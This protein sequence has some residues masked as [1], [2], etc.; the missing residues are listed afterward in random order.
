MTTAQPGIFAQGTRAHYYLELDVLPG[1]D[2]DA[3][4]AALAALREPPVTAGGSNFVIALGPWLWRQLAPAEA[5]ASL[6]DF[7]VIGDPAGR[8]APATQHDI[9]LWFH[10]TN[11]DVVL[12]MA[13]AA[14][15]ALSPVAELA[16]HQPAFVY[17]DSRDMTGFIDGTENS[18]LWEAPAVALVPDGEPGAGGSHVLVMHFVHDLTSFHQL[19]Q[20]EQEGAI[21]RTKPDSVELDAD[22]KPRS[23]HIA[24]VVH[25]DAAGEEIEI[26][27]RSTP[28][29][30]VTEQG[31]Q[32]VAFSADPGRFRLMLRAMYGLED[33]ITDRLLDFTTPKSGALYFAPSM[34]A[35]ADALTG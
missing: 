5:P 27:R 22:V 13:R 35:I 24:R 33:G 8:H 18:P 21:G 31:L 9:W 2:P 32:F 10:G 12:D 4:L 25:E 23:S 30:T 7:E 29:G 26:Y 20:E 1:A 15:A 3:V 17:L 16:T 19:G 11:H 6:Q 34:E 14:A 28:F